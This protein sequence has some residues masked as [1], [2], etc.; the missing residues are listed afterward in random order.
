MKKAL[1]SL[2]MLLAACGV[3]QNQPTDQLGSTGQAEQSELN[4]DG[5]GHHVR[6]FVDN[7]AG[8]GHSSG[9]GINYHGGPVMLGTVNAYYIWYGNW[10]GN[11]ATTIL[12]DFASNIGGSSYEAIN[13]TYY[14]G[15]NTHVSGNV[16]YAGSTTD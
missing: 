13:G 2:S 9:T 11:S 8:H 12:T 7:H 15:S 1:L 4:P 16:S 10:S 5:K 3:E 6:E 14:D